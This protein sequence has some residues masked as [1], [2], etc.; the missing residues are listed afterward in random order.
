VRLKTEAAVADNEFVGVDPDAGEV[1]N[2]SES[3]FQTGVIGVSLISAE[4][5]LRKHV[6]VDKVTAG[7][8]R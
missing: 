4:I 8:G 5:R 1:G 2:E 3:T 7:S 6:D